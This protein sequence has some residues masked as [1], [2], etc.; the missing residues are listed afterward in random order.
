MNLRKRK[1]IPKATC[2]CAVYREPVVSKDKGAGREVDT[3]LRSPSGYLLQIIPVS[4][5][6]CLFCFSCPLP[7]EAR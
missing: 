1:E 7:R 4:A 2:V 6:I 5:D 3:Q